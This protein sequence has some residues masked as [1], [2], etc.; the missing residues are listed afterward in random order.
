MYVPALIRV[1]GFG[2]GVCDGIDDTVLNL[3]EHMPSKCCHSTPGN[4][5]EKKRRRNRRE[6]K[7]RRNRRGKK[8]RNRR[9]KK[10][11]NRRGRG[12][13]GEEQEREEEEEQEKNRRGKEHRASQSWK[14][15]ALYDNAVKCSTAY[16]FLFVTSTM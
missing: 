9:R 5:R 10:R 13:T 16:G 6:R 2:G 11:R 7:K 8:R 12:G 15:D 14:D 4:R 1:I 3:V